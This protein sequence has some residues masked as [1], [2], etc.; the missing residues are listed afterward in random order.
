MQVNRRTPTALSRHSAAF[1]AG[2]L[3]NWSTGH[4]DQTRLRARS[5]GTR[6]LHFRHVPPLGPDM[7]ALI[8]ARARACLVPLG[9]AVTRSS[10]TAEHSSLPARAT[11]ARRRRTG[12]LALPKPGK[13]SLSS[14]LTGVAAEAATYPFTTIEPN[15][16]VVQKADPRLD[17]LAQTVRAAKVVPDTMSSTTSPGSSPVSTAVKVCTSSWPTAAR[18]MR[19]H[20]VRV[21]E[22]PNVVHPEGRVDPL[23]DIDTIETDLIYA[24]LKQAERR[25]ERVARTAQSGER[26]PSH[27]G[28][29]SSSSLPSGRPAR[30]VPPQPTRRMHLR[31]FNP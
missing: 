6:R 19:S 30:T 24:D 26:S 17:A 18:P 13:S 11:R 8:L 9:L 27:H 20:V 12:S 1:R 4:L 14:A 25:L 22:D 15:V 28:S 16:A 3:Q 7:R 31:C 29:T 21:H 5:S 10:R 2:Q 23:A